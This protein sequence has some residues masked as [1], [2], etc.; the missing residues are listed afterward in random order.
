MAVRLSALRVC[1]PLPPPPQG[2]FLVL[3]SVRDRVDPRAIMSL[4]DLSKLKNPITLSGFELATFLL[5]A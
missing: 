4:E 2:R 1:S 5:V 3:I